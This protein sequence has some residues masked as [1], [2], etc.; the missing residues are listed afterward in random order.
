MQQ[1]EKPFSIRENGEGRIHGDFEMIC[2]LLES[3]FSLWGVTMHYKTVR[4][5]HGRSFY[6]NIFIKQQT[7]GVAGRL[8]TRLVDG[9]F[10]VWDLFI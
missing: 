4:L 9:T 7:T 2:L 5:E 8:L 10:Q 1:Q 6:I 3:R